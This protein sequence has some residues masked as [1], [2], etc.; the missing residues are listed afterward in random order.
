MKG[1]KKLLIALVCIISILAIPASCFATTYLTS[2]SR[3]V[4]N[5]AYTEDTIQWYVS[6]TSPWPITGY[7]AW[8][9]K[10]GFFVQNDGITKLGSSTTGRWDFNC[11]N[12]FLAGA[13]LGGV[14]LGFSH[15]CIDQCNV[16]RAGT[17][18]WTYDD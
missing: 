7:D 1:I 13:V 14:T 12:T 8:Q 17:A 15:T 4:P 6:T 3:G 11:Q 5:I 2:S 16:Y 10:S 9:S 18:T